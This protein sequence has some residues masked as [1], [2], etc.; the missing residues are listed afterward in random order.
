MTLR[1]KIAMRILAK[2]YTFL[3]ATVSLIG[4]NVVFSQM[5]TIIT[6]HSKKNKDDENYFHK[7]PCRPNGD[8]SV[9]VFFTREDVKSITSKTRRSSGECIDGEV[10]GFPCKNINLLSLMSL[11]DLDEKKSANDIWGWYD[12]VND[13]EY[14]I[15]GLYSGTAFI[16]V[17]G[18]CVC[19]CS[20][21]AIL[22]QLAIFSCDDHTHNFH[23]NHTD[24]E[25]PKL[26]GVLPA[27]SRGSNWR[28]IKVSC[29]SCVFVGFNKTQFSNNGFTNY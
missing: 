16:D 4:S 21:F 2:A 18:M 29:L 22:Q 1:S 20:R 3:F 5:D 27:H 14:A 28:D 11:N 26:V 12:E 7:T 17:T 9:P 15:L 25:N 10:D 24:G 6:E 19:V 23:S 13:K 8:P